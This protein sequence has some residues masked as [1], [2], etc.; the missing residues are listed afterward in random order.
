LKISQEQL[1]EMVRGEA[2]LKLVKEKG[3]DPKELFNER[4]TVDIRIDG[5]VDQSGY[6][7]GPAV[8]TFQSVIGFPSYIANPTDADGD[9]VP[10]DVPSAFLALLDGDMGRAP[11]GATLSGKLQA[12]RD[13][14][15]ERNRQILGPYTHKAWEIF[16]R[17]NYDPAHVALKRLIRGIDDPDQTSELYRSYLE[18]ELNVRDPF[19][20]S[21]AVIALS[22]E[23]AA[24]TLGYDIP[25]SRGTISGVR[26]ATAF[27]NYLKD[28]S[29]LGGINEYFIQQIS[30]TERAEQERAAEESGTT[31]GTG[32]QTRDVEIPTVPT[33]SRGSTPQNSGESNEDYAARL[34]A[35]TETHQAD[36]QSSLR[37][38]L[39]APALNSPT[40]LSG[41]TF[42]FNYDEYDARQQQWISPYDI[43]ISPPRDYDPGRDLRRGGP[44]SFVGAVHPVFP[45]EK[46]DNLATRI[47]R[48]FEDDFGKDN[49]YQNSGRQLEK[50]LRILGGISRGR[51]G[52][53]T[54]RAGVRKGDV[55]TV[56][57]ATLYLLSKL[58]F[59]DR[60]LRQEIEDDTDIMG[61]GGADDLAFRNRL[62][63]IIDAI[64][65]GSANGDA[66]FPVDSVP[67][68][69]GRWNADS[70]TRYTRAVERQT[71]T[72]NESIDNNDNLLAEIVD[73][74]IRESFGVER[75]FAPFRAAPEPVVAPAAPATIT[76]SPGY[77]EGPIGAIQRRLGAEATGEWNVETQRAF[78]NYVDQFLDRD[79]QG[80]AN[81]IRGHRE[82]PWSIVSTYH[83]SLAN[84]SEGLLAF[85]NNDTW[86]KSDRV[87]SRRR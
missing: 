3:I 75:L 41:N 59:G 80:S 31:P 79:I 73:A 34:Q 56:F 24:R 64:A 32:I 23:G 57:D 87:R 15:S 4:R 55:N 58:R 72:T 65:P 11:S 84:N 2:L 53:G 10:E 61:I 47:K 39:S 46:L 22:W 13:A 29:S 28:G 14:L 86:F 83:P 17:T 77:N 45:A 12:Y 21:V 42:I 60:N 8:G 16:V 26:A 71:G 7:N 49:L 44:S 43:L 35:T 78:N 6:L 67:S 5:T 9:G 33:V 40:R 48:M 76:F 63:A 37:T 54:G 20:P 38:I 82:Q 25:T 50:I 19:I 30:A 69:A 52:T 68:G 51:N 36:L 81:I 70:A 27:A 66:A 62:I 1:V 74:V 18:E 85:I